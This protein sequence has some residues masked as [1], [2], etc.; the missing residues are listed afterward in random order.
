MIKRKVLMI[1]AS[2]VL[3]LVILVLIVTLTNKNSPIEKAAQYFKENQK[4]L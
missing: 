1:S 3:I 2:I 4:E